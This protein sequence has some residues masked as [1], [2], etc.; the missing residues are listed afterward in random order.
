MATHSNILAWRIAWT[1]EPGDRGVHG[2][3]NS[4]TRLS[5]WRL[6]L[7]HFPEGTS[8]FPRETGK[9]TLGMST[10]QPEICR[11]ILV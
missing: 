5:G 1:E 7:V 10:A 6:G 3:A 8:C 11:G 9:S 2:I 4:R